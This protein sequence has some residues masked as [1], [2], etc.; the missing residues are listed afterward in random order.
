MSADRSPVFASSRRLLPSRS[1]SWCWRRRVRDQA[2]PV[3]RCPALSLTK[4]TN[5]FAKSAPLGHGIW[6]NRALSGLLQPVHSAHSAHK[7]RGSEG[8]R[9]QKVD[10]EISFRRKQ[11]KVGGLT[12][13]VNSSFPLER[14]FF[15]QPKRS[16]HLADVLFWG[17]SSQTENVQDTKSKPTDCVFPRLFDL[18]LKGTDC[19]FS[20][21]LFFVKG[22]G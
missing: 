6:G 10:E 4:S 21:V 22:T 12:L 2:I 5:V 18:R 19:L 13:P 9:V 20:F 7:A 17:N 3:L 1:R 8:V 15:L 11:Q 14:S 16:Q